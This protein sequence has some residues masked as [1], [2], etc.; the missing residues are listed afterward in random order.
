VEP[1]NCVRAAPE[2]KQEEERKSDTIIALDI[3]TTMTATDPWIL[4]LYA[5]KA[6]P[7]A[8]FLAI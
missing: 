6:P 5:L 8:S 4:F 1:V 3:T 7:L 2:Q